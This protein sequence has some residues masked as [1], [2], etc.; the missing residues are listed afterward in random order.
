LRPRHVALLLLLSFLWGTAYLFMRASAPAFG[1]APM[2]F[3]RMALASLL[4]LLPLTIARTGLAPLRDNW[5]R[6]LVMG[7]AFTALPFLGLGYSALAIEAGLMAILQSTAPLFAAIVG[8]LW[9]GERVTRSRAAGLAVG[10][11]GVG[12][13]VWDKVG[14]IEAASLAILTT[15]AVT[16]MWGVSANYARARMAH[17]D[18]IALATGSLTVAALLLAPLAW[19]TWPAAMPDAK[20]WAEVAFLGVG[21]S[22]FGFLIYFALLRQVGAVRTVSV[23]FLNPVVAMLSAVVY[24][25]E[26]ITLRMVAGCA[27]ILAGTSLTLG[28]LPVGRRRAKAPSGAR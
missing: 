1:A 23:T 8:H 28:L 7:G 10:F 25:G 21:S 3:L 18:P 17:V 26:P 6:M 16:A 24:L 27:V 15:L 22:G 20:A 13:L 14:A 4:V 5:R 19:F 2:I 12:V 11:A 9:L